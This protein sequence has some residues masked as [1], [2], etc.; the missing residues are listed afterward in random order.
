MSALI[1]GQ[2]MSAV[3][4]QLV[5]EIE[6]S[7]YELIA[8]DVDLMGSITLDVFDPRSDRYMTWRYNY[9]GEAI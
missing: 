2:P 8:A 4:R 1:V 7:G 5:A 6:Q 3:Q 9:R